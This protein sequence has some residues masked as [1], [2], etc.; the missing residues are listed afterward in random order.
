MAY[1]RVMRAP[2]PCALTRA[3]AARDQKSQSE[4]FAAAT[5]AYRRLSPSA[6]YDQ[7]AVSGD[8]LVRW[9]MATA[10]RK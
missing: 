6:G 10:L 1:R 4:A 5:A 2:S 9:F 7:L 3:D 8:F